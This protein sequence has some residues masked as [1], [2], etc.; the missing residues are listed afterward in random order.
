MTPAERERYKNDVCQYCDREGHVAKICWWIPQDKPNPPP[1]ALTAL[2]LD[3]DVI[4]T[5]WIADSGASNHMTGNKKLLNQMGNYYGADSIAIGDGTFLSIDGVES[6]SIKQKNTL[7][8]SNFLS[9]PALKQNLLSVGQLTDEYSVNCEFSNVSVFVKDRQTGQVLLQ[10]P[11]NN[12]LYILSGISKAYFANRLKTVTADIW[13]QRLGHPQSSAISTLSNKNLIDVKG[14]LHSKSFCDSCQLGKLSKIPF[15]LSTNKS[16][17]MFEK[18]HCDLWGPA[19]VM[20]FAKFKYYA[21]LVDDYSKYSWLIPLRTKSEFFVAFKAFEQYVLRQFGQKIKIFH[22][23]GGGEFLNNAL[24]SHFL[25]QGIK[26]QEE[27]HLTSSCMVLILIIA[28]YAYLDQNSCLCVFIGYSEKYKGYKCLNPKT[29]KIIISRHVKFD[30]TVF[31]Y[32]SASSDKH[33]AAQIINSWLPPA[34]TNTLAISSDGSTGNFSHSAE[35]G[36][37]IVSEGAAA[38][39]DQSATFIPPPQPLQDTVLDAVSAPANSHAAATLQ[40]TAERDAVL[41][42]PFLPPRQNAEH[43]A[44]SSQQILTPSEQEQG[45]PQTPPTPKGQRLS[46]CHQCVQENTP[47]TSVTNVLDRHTPA[48]QRDNDEENSEAHPVEQLQIEAEHPRHSMVTRS[49]SGIVKPNPRYALHVSVASNVPSEPR[50]VKSALAHVGWKQAMLE[51]YNALQS[52]HTWTLVPRPANVN[53]I[54]CK[55][56]YKAKLNSDGTLDRLKARLVAKGFLQLDGVDYTETFSPVIKPGTIRLILTVALARHWPIRQLD[57]KNAFL[58]GFI[59]EDIYMDQPPGITD[60]KYPNH[61]CK[62]QRAL[63]GLKQAPRAWFDRLSTF[64]I[65]YGFVCSLADPSLF[66]QHTSTG[67]LVL[68]IYVDDMLLIGSSMALVQTFLQVLSTEFSMKD[69]GPLHHFLGIQVHSTETGLHLNQSRYAYSIL[70]RAQ[71]VD[72]QPMPTPLVQRVD[73]TSDATPL[74]DPTHFRG[75]VGSL[76]YLTL[77]R[78]DLSYSVNFVSQFMQHPTMSHFKC[79]RR[80]LRYLKGT[81]HYGLS[82]STDTSLVLSA[83]SDADWAGCPTTRRSTTG[84]CTFLGSN[85]ISWCAKK[86]QTVARSSTEAEYRSLAH[87]AAELTWLGYILDDLRIQPTRPPVLYGD[88]LSALHLIRIRFTQGVSMWLWIITMSRTC[89]SRSSN[90]EIHSIKISNRYIYKIHDLKL[91]LAQFR[92]KLCLFPAIV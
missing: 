78:P 39:L 53:V 73:L 84:Y 13:H 91:A 19:P 65:D 20:S 25:S 81:I 50:T 47:T 83:F 31:P 7:P 10:G 55:W 12:N 33:F 18:V 68:L 35:Q 63:Y 40:H 52:N 29:K 61:V 4:D 58:H 92:R 1:Q 76:Q 54:G 74:S 56:V 49:Q 62:L 69:L 71:M 41:T 30:E 88:N 51:E 3:N 89:C 5:D 44:V 86:Q 66:V 45:E 70:E 17:V 43:E 27:R 80:I 34:V 15:S 11:R 21:C 82:F 22:S 42:Q 8:I 75:L 2:T 90:H 72:C 14:S 57:V 38:S 26:H 32:K 9:V 79:L 85:I 48:S 77:T 6:A 67:I 87:A 16:T 24:S 60:P 64:L 59:T 46:D 28:P 36:S 23:D 37:M